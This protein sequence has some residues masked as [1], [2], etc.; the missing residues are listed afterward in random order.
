LYPWY[1]AGWLGYYEPPRVYR[2][3]AYISATTLYDVRRNGLVWSGTVQTTAPGNLN[4]EI[5]H[6]VATVVKAF[7]KANVIERS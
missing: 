6:Y 4:K 2:Y 3:D 5:Q 1:S 7:K